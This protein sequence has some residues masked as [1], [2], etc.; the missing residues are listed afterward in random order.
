MKCLY[1]KVKKLKKTQKKC[2]SKKCSMKYRYS[3]LRTHKWTCK[4]CHK[5]KLV[6]KTWLK[7]I[8]CSQSC[9]ATWKMKQPK[10][11]ARIFN[12]KVR[13]KVGLSIKKYLMEHPEVTRKHSKRMKLHNPMHM[14][15]VKQKMIATRTANGTLGWMGSRGGNG[16]LTKPQVLLAT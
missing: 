12:K 16:Q 6:T 3:L 9:L 13:K 2:C 1:C 4:E 14:K 8:F 5:E 7:A 11:R 10:Y 15:G